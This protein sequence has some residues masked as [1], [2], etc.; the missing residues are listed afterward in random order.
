MIALP[1]LAGVGCPDGT[2]SGRLKPPATVS[3]LYLLFSM[4]ITGITRLNLT[5]VS[6]SKSL[7]GVCSADT[8]P[9]SIIPAG[10]SRYDDTR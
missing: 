4:S 9:E 3:R 2:T 8:I 5:S 7:P 6:S 10:R 1:P